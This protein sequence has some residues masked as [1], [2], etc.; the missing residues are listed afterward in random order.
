MASFL[1]VL[2]V[3][4]IRFIN[5]YMISTDLKHH[6]DVNSLKVKDT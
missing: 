2:S 5:F 4:Q 6:G 1:P 3:L